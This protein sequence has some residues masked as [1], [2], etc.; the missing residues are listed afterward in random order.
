MKLK[1]FLLF[2][3]TWCTTSALKFLVMNDIHLNVTETAFIPLPDNETTIG[4]FGVMLD[5]MKE[6]E[7][8]SGVPIDAIIIPG[9]FPRH[10]MA[11][12][13][14]EPGVP[15]GWP[16][17]LAT[18]NTVISMITAVFP[19]TPILPSIGNNDVMYHNQAPTQQQAPGYYQDLW[20]AWFSNVPANVALDNSSG[21]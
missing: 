11:A 2:A 15:P 18:I 4:L 9:D 20:T 7:T 8:K 5:D 17:Q 19:D 12:W 21:N 6:Q 3:L 16:A 1:F 10:N 13:N 14:E